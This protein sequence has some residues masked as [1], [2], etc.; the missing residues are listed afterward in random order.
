MRPTQGTTK[1]T[2]SLVEAA[3][4]VVAATG[5]VLPATA[6]GQE[7]YSPS[8]HWAYASYF[9]TGW[10][11]LNDRQSAFVIS[12]NPT[13]YRNSLDWP[14]NESGPA[15]LRIFA[16]FTIGAA[17]LD[18]DDIPGIVDPDNL[19]IVSLG[20]GADLELPLSPRWSLRPN[21][22]LSYGTPIDASDYA[23]S[24][25]ADV[26]ARYSIGRGRTKWWLQGSLGTVGYE[27]NRGSDDRFTYAGLAVEV[28][29]P[30][31]WFRLGDSQAVMHFHVR[32]INYFDDISVE[33][34][35]NIF[36]SVTNSWEIGAALGKLDGRIR[37]WRVEF[38]RLGLSYSY[39]PSGELRGIGIVFRSIWEP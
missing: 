28:A 17:S 24:Y 21:L 16:P 13:V 36:D 25:Q 22:R 34:G 12:A 2:A 11:R 29:S 5:L 23:W 33:V 15:E 27:A 26:K 39:S 9:G 32:H 6:M 7:R 38:D 31:D 14:Q 18:F 10:Y 19:S 1:I 8:I 30:I 20:A 37:L 4:C 35:R 3:T